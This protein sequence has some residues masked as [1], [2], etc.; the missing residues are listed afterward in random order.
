MTNAKLVHKSETRIQ[1][2]LCSNLQ[3][4]QSSLSYE[5]V[6]SQVW[7]PPSTPTLTN[8]REE[9]NIEKNVSFDINVVI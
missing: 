2:C 5:R 4:A 9:K 6:D 3:V 8:V 7:P 1:H